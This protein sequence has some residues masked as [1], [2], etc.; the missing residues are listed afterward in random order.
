MNEDKIIEK[1]IEHEALFDQMS[2]RIGRLLTQEDYARS[3]DQMMVMLKRIDEERP[4]T[5]EWIR[6]VEEE[7]HLW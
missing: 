3:S 6:R 7:V 2:E 1:L 5:L 4:F